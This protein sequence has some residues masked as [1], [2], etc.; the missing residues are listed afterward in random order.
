M[1]VRFTRAH[2][3]IV[4]DEEGRRITKKKVFGLALSKGALCDEHPLSSGRHYVEFTYCG[5]SDDIGA[6]FGVAKYGLGLC[7]DLES[8]DGF[9]GYSLFAGQIQ[10]IC[11]TEEQGICRSTGDEIEWEG[12]ESA[13]LADR[14]GLLLDLDV[15]SLSVYKNDRK[16]GVMCPPGTFKSGERYFWAVMLWSGK[17]AVQIEDSK[18]V[19]PLEQS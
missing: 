17:D 7:G 18:P 6:E 16:L 13:E 19:P 12:M 4:I 8:S 2:K 10:F 14:I 1:Q 9:W 15:G 11:G 3:N 5:R